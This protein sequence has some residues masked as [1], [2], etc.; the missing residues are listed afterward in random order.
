MPTITQ[1]NTQSQ[2][3]HKQS[4]DVI[5]G[6]VNSPV[7]AFKGVGGTPIFFEKAKGPHLYDVD[8]NQYIDYVGSWGAMIHGH[9]APIIQKA[10]LKAMEQTTSFGAPTPNEV[11]LAAK[12]IELVPSVEKLRLVNS[13][14][15]ATM[16]AIRM[17]RAYTKRDKIIKFEGC[18]HGHADPFL[19][20]AG[21]GLA[22]FG[23]PDSLG[24]PKVCAKDTLVAPYNDLN[25]VKK[26]FEQYSSEIAAIIIEPIAGNMNMIFAEKDFLNG[27][28]KLTEQYNSILIFDEVM[29]GFRVGLTGAQ[30]YF[31]IQ[32]DITTFGKVIGGGLPVGAIGG[33]KNLMEILAPIGGCY[34][35][36]TLSG[37]PLAT[38]AG[39]ASLTALSE[40]NFFENLEEKSKSL[41]DG[42]HK[43][44]HKYDIPLS[45]DALGGMLGFYFS[46]KKASCFQDIA[47]I[48]SILFQT[49]FHQMLAN[50]IYL[51]PSMYEA[52]FISS[53][54]SSETIKKTLLGAE[55]SFTK[56]AE[57][58]L[59]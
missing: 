37:N 31:N 25:A 36:G 57:L 33:H 34:Q 45:G 14:T 4:L 39:L 27:L 11:R 55:N 47:N 9:Q 24:I 56:M 35:A 7:R 8:D 18:Y 2:F 48:P 44:S 32:P 59:I 58:N 13:G 22:T 23:Q 1:N 16:T 40:D 46:G 6:G 30:G 3:W 28:K 12:V 52:A 41:L 54:H 15:E 50:N 38:A 29:T 20:K 5:P 49:F 19:V 43:L 26:L 10:I 53:A 51:P 42:M 21:S 17:A